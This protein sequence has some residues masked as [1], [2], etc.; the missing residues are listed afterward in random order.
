MISILLVEDNQ[1]K[2]SALASIIEECGLEHRLVIEMNVVDAKKELQSKRFDLLLLDINLPRRAATDPEI[3]G[4]LELLRWLKARGQA[5]RPSYVVGIT[6][7]EDSFHRAQAEFNNLIWQVISV[8]LDE[9]GWR[10][11][12]RETIIAIAGQIRPPFVGDGVSHKSDVLVITALAAPELSAVLRLHADFQRIEVSHDASLYYRGRLA[13]D[14]QSLNVIAVSASD[15]GL[16]GAAISATKGILAFWPKYLFMTGIT[17]GLKGRTEIGDVVFADL[18]WDWG[19]GK[20]RKV[21]GAEQFVPAPYQRRLDE[22]LARQ[23]K[24]LS[25]DSVFLQKVWNG[26]TMVKPKNPPRILLGAMASGASVLQSSDAVKRVLQQHK[27]VLAI[28]MEA[29]SIM[30]AAHVAPLPRPLPIVA[31]SVCDNGDGKKNDKFQGYAAYTSARV[32]EEFALRYLIDKDV[33]SKGV[34]H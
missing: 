22:T 24:E 33:S 13:K 2:I 19:S 26:A 1:A 5:H 14:R 21:K 25:G 31:K 32:F 3:D 18:S 11:Q 9:S 15:K 12:V 17:A 27:D 30:F 10:S 29:F 7:Y 34:D 28:E 4:G 6:S 16:S 8:K 20:L 23:V